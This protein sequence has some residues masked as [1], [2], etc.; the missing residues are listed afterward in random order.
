[1]VQMNRIPRKNGYLAS[2]TSTLSCVLA[3]TLMFVAS[4]TMAQRTQP[5]IKL[6]SKQQLKKANDDMNGMKESVSVM[7]VLIATTGADLK[8][9]DREE[10]IVSTPM[11]RSV[12]VP[13]VPRVKL[14]FLFV[15]NTPCTQI[16]FRFD[17]LVS[18]VPS[19]F[20]HL[21]PRIRFQL[22]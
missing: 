16:A 11:L 13:E 3:I 5:T 21:G 12:L 2:I 8:E 14:F 15:S 10:E 1:M 6:S 4:N 18:N 22:R 17:F 20:L 9:E 7:V 19:R